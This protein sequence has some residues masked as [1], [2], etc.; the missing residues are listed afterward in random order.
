MAATKKVPSPIT[1]LMVVIIIAAIATWLVPAGKYNTL[2]V[3]DNNNFVVNGNNSISTLPFTQQTLDSLHIKI[4][5]LKFK[6]GAIRK[7]VSIPGTYYALERNGQGIVP[8]LQAPLK[9][10]MDSIDIILFILVIGGFMHIFNQSGAMEKGLQSLT[11]TMKGRESWLIIILTFL[12]SFAGASYGMAEE[13]MVFY[14]IMVPLFLA[15]GYDLLIPVAVIFGGTQLGTLASVSNPFSTIIASN[16]AGVNWADGLTERMLMAV[17]STIIFIWYI[18]R[19]ANKIKKDPSRS[20]VLKVDG[21]VPSLYPSI[22]KDGDA[23]PKLDTRTKLLLLLFLATFATMITGVVKFDW[24]LTEMSTLFLAASI[25]LGFILKLGEKKFVTQFIDGAKELLAVAFIVGVARGVTIVLNDGHI[26]D[27]ILYYSAKLVGNMPPALF[28]VILMCLYMVF[29]L[30]ISSSSGMAVLTMPIMGALAIIINV[31]GREI[32][33]AYLYGMGIMGFITPTGLILPALALSN[34]SLKAWLKF[35]YPLMII[36][37]LLC[38][39]FLI[40]GIYL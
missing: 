29:T 17:I 8:L 35:I 25:L 32:V 21:P 6:E 19:Y 4:A 30:F 5:L 15:A 24:W 34:V 40:A 11:H 10:I 2:S 23:V 26:S 33:N 7:P 31:P 16:A 28:I 9:G 39:A 37:L 14:P 18:V 3:G 27:S 12:F 36:L 22:E 20:I 1:I 13:A 38:A